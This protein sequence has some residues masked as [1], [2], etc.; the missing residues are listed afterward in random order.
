V[1]QHVSLTH[2]GN[3]LLLQQMMDKQGEG[4]TST[5]ATATTRGG[6]AEGDGDANNELSVSRIQHDVYAAL[7]RC[8]VAFRPFEDVTV[9]NRLSLFQQFEVR[10]H[11]ASHELADATYRA[12]HNCTLSGLRCRIAWMPTRF[13]R[14]DT[15]VQSKLARDQQ[16]RVM[17]HQVPRQLQQQHGDNVSPDHDG[18]DAATMSAAHYR[19]S[20]ALQQQPP[21]SHPHQ[22]PDVT[23]GELRSTLDPHAGAAT[24]ESFELLGARDRRALGSV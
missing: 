14:F 18:T 2:G 8:G 3:M 6:G 17:Q 12:L 22:Q 13:T 15:M 19:G 9:S 21:H 7:T 20:D 5:S 23:D 1:L 16:Q 11:C 24:L 4:H 10:I